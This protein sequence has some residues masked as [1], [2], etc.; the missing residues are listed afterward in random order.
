MKKNIDSLKNDLKK[1]S[2]KASITVRLDDNIKHQF[3]QVCND[4]GLTVS[5]CVSAF[6]NK[7][8][9]TRSIP[10]NITTQR[11][12]RKIGI[13]NGKY[14]FDDDLFDK[15]DNDIVKMFGE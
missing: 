4:L 1:N 12:K 13:A 7:V 9:H 3:E 6:V 5:S 10:F 14:N 11:V 2:L 8:V 15:L